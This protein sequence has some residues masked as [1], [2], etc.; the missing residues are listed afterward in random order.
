MT[1]VTDM[2]YKSANTT[3]KCCYRFTAEICTGQM[4]CVCVHMCMS[5]LQMSALHVGKYSFGTCGLK[6]GKRSALRMH[7]VIC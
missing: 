6:N 2:E 4:P 5:V 1:V 3:S 7:S